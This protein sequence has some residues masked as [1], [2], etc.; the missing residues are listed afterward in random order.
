[1]NADQ[2]RAGLRAMPMFANKTDAELD[3]TLHSFTETFGFDLGDDMDPEQIV[4]L[5]PHILDELLEEARRELSGVELLALE[6]LVRGFQ[7]VAARV[8]TGDPAALDE[9]HRMSGL[10]FGT[11]GAS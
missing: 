7:D 6:L 8:S 10:L 4:A 2:M 1:M 9:L 11:G 5:T 3:E